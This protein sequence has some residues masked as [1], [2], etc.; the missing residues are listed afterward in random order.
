M[1][2]WGR[3]L[4]EIRNDRGTR[5]RCS[6]AAFRRRFQAAVLP[7]LL[8][9]VITMTAG[10]GQTEQELSNVIAYRDTMNA[11]F[12]SLSD[13]EKEINALDAGQSNASGQLLRAMDQMTA[14]VQ[15]A[16][17]T[18][19]PSQFSE[20]QKLAQVAAASMQ[21]TD[22]LFHQALDNDFN[23]DAFSS[24][25]ASYEDACGKI[26]EMARS[27]RENVP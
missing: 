19:A 11:L 13:C 24:A 14:A 20:V 21:T 8:C 26:G 1:Q 16:S 6:I 3:F 23:A 17:E 22:S 9:I 27:M 7:P 15:R 10:C 12:T 18:D 5:R 4:H 2:I 25:L